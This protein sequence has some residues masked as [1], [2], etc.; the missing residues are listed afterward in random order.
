VELFRQPPTVHW[1][2]SPGEVAAKPMTKPS[3]PPV[4]LARTEKAYDGPST[5][6]VSSSLPFVPPAVCR[7]PPPPSGSQVPDSSCQAVKSGAGA[8]SVPMGPMRASVNSA[9]V[10]AP[11]AMWTPC[12]AVSGTGGGA[13]GA[14]VR[15]TGSAVSPAFAACTRWTW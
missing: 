14:P 2:Q 10:P 4:F 8:G 6:S 9:R 13:W 12:R 7:T 15:V 11:V 1:Y 5:A 3:G